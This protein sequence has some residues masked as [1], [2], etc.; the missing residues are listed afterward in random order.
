MEI[1][2]PR[3]AQGL[4]RISPP[5][6]PPLGALTLTLC[7]ELQQCALQGGDLPSPSP[8][9]HPRV[10]SPSPTHRPVFLF[11]I[12]F[13]LDD[14]LHQHPHYLSVT[15]HTYLPLA[16]HSSHCGRRLVALVSRRSSIS[17]A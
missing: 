2:C 8:L 13:F 17:R 7:C 6:P 9:P 5:S 11:C 3:Q 4:A 1:V 14:Q 12:H 16:V 15:P 10:P